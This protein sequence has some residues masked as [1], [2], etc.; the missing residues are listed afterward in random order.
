VKTEVGMNSASLQRKLNEKENNGEQITEAILEDP[1]LIAEVMAGISTAKSTV[2]FKCA[3]ILSLI[4]ATKPDTLYATFDFFANLLD[5]ENN[6]LKWNA[7]D[8][9]ANLAAVDVEDKFD[10]IFTK[11]YGLLN[12]GSLITAAH[13]VENSGKIARAKPQLRARIARAILKVGEIPLPTAECRNI[14]AGKLIAAFS[15]HP[16]LVTDEKAVISFVTGQLNNTRNATKK[17]ASAFLRRW[18]RPRK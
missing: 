17:K 15:E 2:R 7:I 1:S 8:I 12:E 14:L 5:S 11:Y 18:A 16:E 13:V 9:L 10:R 4:S 6:I 3:K